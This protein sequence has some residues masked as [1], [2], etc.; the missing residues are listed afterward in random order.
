MAADIIALPTDAITVADQHLMYQ[1]ETDST[2][3]D[4]FRLCDYRLRRTLF[5]QLR[6]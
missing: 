3:D 5:W 2:I 4:A 6:S 1:I